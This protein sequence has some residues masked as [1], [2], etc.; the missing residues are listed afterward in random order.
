[1]TFCL[2]LYLIFLKYIC[3][4]S[5]QLDS[6]DTAKLDDL[7]KQLDDAEK[8]LRENNLDKQFVDLENANNEVIDLV[9]K[10]KREYDD[11][12]KDVENIE[13]IMNSLPDGCFKNIE[14]ETA[15]G[16]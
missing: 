4:I 7:E 3:F 8:L 11:L 9:L 2:F 15:P 14:I 16:T 6:V 1:M 5:D 10:S 12:K 13:Q